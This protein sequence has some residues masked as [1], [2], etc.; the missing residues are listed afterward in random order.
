V[1]SVV[2][3]IN[4]PRYPSLTGIRKAKKVEVPTWDAA[5]L[6]LK[7]EGVGAGASFAVL[8]RIYRP[9][10]REGGEVMSGEPAETAKALAERLIDQ[11]L[12]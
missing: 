9:P 3:E 1:I 6:E 7:A 12:I 2:K 4:E 11:G 8:E 5:A 10:A